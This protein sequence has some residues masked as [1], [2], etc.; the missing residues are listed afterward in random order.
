MKKVNVY[1]VIF[2]IMAIIA[3]VRNNNNFFYLTFLLLILFYCFKG[4]NSVQF[5]L[6]CLIHPKKEIQFIGL[7]IFVALNVKI[8][9]IKVDKLALYFISWITFTTLIN[10]LFFSGNIIN[11][12]LE[13]GIYSLFLLV[14]II[15]REKDIN[16]DIDENIIRIFSVQILISLIQLIITK[17]TGDTIS[18]TMISAHYLGVFLLLFMYYY[19]NYCKENIIPKGKK[20]I[21]FTMSIFILYISDAKHVYISFIIAIVI[22]II[23]KWL[24]IKKSLILLS[25]LVCVIMAIGVKLAPQ[26]SIRN[27]LERYFPDSSQYIYNEKYNQKYKY[28]DRTIDNVIS[29]RGII[30]YGVGQYGS[31]VCISRVGDEIYSEK[32]KK[33]FGDHNYITPEYNDAID[34]IMTEEYVKNIK[35]ISM[36]LSYPLVS[37]VPFITE[38]G[39]VGFLLFIKILQ[40]LGTKKQNTILVLFFFLISIFDLYFEI[41]NVFI[42]IV[43]FSM[44]SWKK[45]NSKMSIEQKVCLLEGK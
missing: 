37:I 30:G 22:Y 26:Q 44:Y 23:F 43:I 11:M 2:T 5:L 7:V 15:L 39:I 36:V 13:T 32:D 18:G 40:R 27:L 1:I 9:L 17:K 12:I 8:I 19:A 45:S 25:T 35:N 31:Q 16:K 14:I 21:I 24:N 38:L 6:L 41:P 20:I 42:F 4:L 3:Q 29:L 34:G 10:I 28:F 33:R